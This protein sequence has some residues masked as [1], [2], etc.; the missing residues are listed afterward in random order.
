MN[1][2]NDL[3]SLP[4]QAARPWQKWAALLGSAAA[5]FALDQ[6]SKAWVVANLRLGE[7]L[8]PIPAIGQYFALTR[9]LN[10]GAAFSILP[11]AGDLF[12]LIALI[13]IGGIIIFYPRM[14]EGHWLERFAYGLLLGGVAGNALDR[15]RLGYVVDFVLLQFRPLISNVSNLADHAIV[16]GI[17]MLFVAQWQSDR[18]RKN[19][20]VPSTNDG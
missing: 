13:M 19:H 17:L 20:Q 9:S 12:L 5:V 16:I 10:T 14:A 8:T 3:P 1:P 15:I 11:Q 6:L 7:S 18:A 4:V 2:S